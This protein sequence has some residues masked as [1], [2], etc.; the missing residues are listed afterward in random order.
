MIGRVFVA[1]DHDERLQIIGVQSGQFVVQNLKR[2]GPARLMADE[3]RRIYSFF[4]PVPTR[5]SDSE[6]WADLGRRFAGL[7][8]EGSE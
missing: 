6:G 1:K 5:R 8:Y 3:D 7:R 4:D 2:F